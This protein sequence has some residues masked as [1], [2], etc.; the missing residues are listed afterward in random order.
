[1]NSEPDPSPTRDWDELVVRARADQPPP[2]NLDRVLR[3][4][5]IAAGEK[6]PVMS[7]A[8]DFA[9][10]FGARRALAFCLCSAFALAVITTWQVSEVWPALPWAEFL[11]VESGDAL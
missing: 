2:L 8:D 11:V 6:T 4:V 5:R 9:A 7:W 3:A 1:M 10:L